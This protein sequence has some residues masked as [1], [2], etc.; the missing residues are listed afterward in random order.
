VDTLKVHLEPTG[1]FSPAMVR[2]ARALARHAPPNVKVVDKRKDADLLVLYVIGL[3]AVEFVSQ[4]PAHQHVAVVQCCLYPGVLGKY[5]PWHPLWKRAKLVWSYY[6]LIAQ[7]QEVGFRFYHSPLGLDPAFANTDPAVNDPRPPLVVTCGR[8]SGPGCEA[9]EEVWK[10]ALLADHQVIH[11]GPSNVVGVSRADYPNV[12]FVQP[13]DPA[14]ADLYLSSRW[15]AALRHVEG[16]ELPAAEGLVC[17]AR[18]I[19][20]DQ[21][22][23]RHWY[24]GNCAVFVPDVAG[25]S[26][27][28]TLASLFN[29]G[30]NPVTEHERYRARARFN[31]ADI[32]EGFWSQVAMSELDGTGPPPPV[33]GYRRY[34]LSPASPVDDWTNT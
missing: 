4:L 17:G 11:L 20:F 19:L 5:R 24:T 32:C 15:V 23:L 29:T 27:V 31:W 12:S 1:M 18:P 6:D 22:A 7:S 21:P 13:K 16:F 28:N 30:Y 26:L 34:K 9:I 2:I 3:D 8:V 33:N 25:A 10:A 14:L